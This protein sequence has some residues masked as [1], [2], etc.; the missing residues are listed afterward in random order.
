MRSHSHESEHP[1]VS[2]IPYGHCAAL[3]YR[4]PC[5]R[6]RLCYALLRQSIC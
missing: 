5:F 1:N 3:R 2:T 4:L 6:L